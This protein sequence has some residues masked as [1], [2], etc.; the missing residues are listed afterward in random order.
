MCNPLQFTTPFM[1]GTRGC[2]L[3][4]ELLSKVQKFYSKQTQALSKTEIT[5]LNKT[6]S[7]AQG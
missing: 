1:D 6:Y 7:Y 3:F 4:W 5:A 2:G